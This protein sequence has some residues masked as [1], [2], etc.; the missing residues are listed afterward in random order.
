MV[1]VV[2]PSSAV[3]VTEI[4]R[5][6]P[7]RFSVEVVTNHR[8]FIERDPVWNRS[9]EESVGDHQFVRDEEASSVRD[10]FS[11]GGNFKFQYCQ[12][13]GEQPISIAP[14]MRDQVDG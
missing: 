14:L 6:P 9:V 8:A 3:S 13:A 10:C 12:G 11:Q 5:Q 4:L 7:G 2:R 1:F